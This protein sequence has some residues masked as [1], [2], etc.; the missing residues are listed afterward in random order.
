VEEDSLKMRHLQEHDLTNNSIPNKKSHTDKYANTYPDLRISIIIPAYN[1]EKRI[2]KC[3]T[4]TLQYCIEQQWDFEIL[5]A[6]DGSIDNTAKIVDDFH[7][8]DNRIKLISLK[9]RMGKGGAL[10][11]ATKNASGGYIAYMDADLSA[12]P[13]EIQRLLEHIDNYHIVVGSR[14]L[15]GNLPP[16]KRP[17]TR[18]IFSHIYS[19]AFRLLSRLQIYDPQCGLK[20]LRRNEVLKILPEIKTTGFAFDSEL[21]VIASIHGLR[22]KEVPINWSHDEGS[23]IDIIKQTTTM[24]RDLLLIWKKARSLHNT[25]RLLITEDSQIVKDRWK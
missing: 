21:L 22:I 6:V 7:S 14:V 4:R 18:A 16:I 2:R 3:L 9:D 11:N 8:E 1:E 5:V 17:M 13:S 23:K 24:G 19:I 12:D 15:R 25:N 10:M 20:I